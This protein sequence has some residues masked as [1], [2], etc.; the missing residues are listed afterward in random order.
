M[1]KSVP[2]KK[3]NALKTYKVSTLGCLCVHP[4]QKKKFNF[5]NNLFLRNEMNLKDLFQHIFLKHSLI[6]LI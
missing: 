1:T 4:L 3:V 5:Q 2:V 6:L